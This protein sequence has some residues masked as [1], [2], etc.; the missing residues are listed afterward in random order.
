MSAHNQNPKERA[1]SL[2]LTLRSDSGYEADTEY[3]ISA[4]QWGEIIRIC[5]DKD[6]KFTVKPKAEGGGA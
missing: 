1:A 6:E 3:R 5:E 2:A 4:E